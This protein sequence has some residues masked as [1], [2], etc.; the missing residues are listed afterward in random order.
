MPPKPYGNEGGG[1]G[2]EVIF[3]F[4]PVNGSVRASAIDAATG[5]EVQVVGPAGP[6]SQTSLKRVALAKL[7]QRLV[8]EG[9]LSGDKETPPDRGPSGG[10]IIV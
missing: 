10:G 2:R 8:R 5:I 4:V 3:E 9:Y 1:G 7:R 6:A